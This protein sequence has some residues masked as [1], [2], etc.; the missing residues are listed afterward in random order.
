MLQ[1]V[2]KQLTKSKIQELR[3]CLFK[4]LNFYCL[5]SSEINQI[6]SLYPPA[7]L[8]RST[9]SLRN[10]LNLLLNSFFGKILYIY[11]ISSSLSPSIFFNS[12]FL[13]CLISVLF[14]TYTLLSL[15]LSFLS[16]F[17]AFLPI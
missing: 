9:L 7:P 16:S 11:L 8:S 4:A 15:L 10:W 14:S 17:F 1:Q 6:L 13:F 3:K 2:A 12:S 5:F